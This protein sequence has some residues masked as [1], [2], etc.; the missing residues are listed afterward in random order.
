MIGI[1]IFLYRV[2]VGISAAYNASLDFM[3]DHPL[4][5]SGGGIAVWLLKKEEILRGVIG[6]IS[7]YIAFFIVVI[8]AILKWKELTKGRTNENT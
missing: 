6:T 8:T 3:Q 5:I 4:L 1:W 2:A 7:V